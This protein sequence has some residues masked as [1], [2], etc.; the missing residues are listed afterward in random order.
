[1]PSMLMW[2]IELVF[3]LAGATKL[4]EVHAAKFYNY[5]FT[6][7]TSAFSGVHSLL[8]ESVGSRPNTVKAEACTSLAPGGVSGTASVDASGVAPRIGAEA[9]RGGDS[10]QSRSQ[11]YKFLQ[12]WLANQ[13]GQ[14]CNP[15]IQIISG[16]V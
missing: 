8:A 9:F 13:P 5:C 10:S 3:V 16:A 2:L 6:H 7:T 1:M 4:R 14:W 15:M 12:P 11:E